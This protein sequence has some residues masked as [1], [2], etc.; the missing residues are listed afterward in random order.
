MINAIQPIH[1]GGHYDAVISR[2]RIEGAGSAFDCRLELPDSVRISRPRGFTDPEEFDITVEV[3]NMAD[4]AKR[5]WYIDL[6]LPPRLELSGAGQSLR[7]Q[8]TPDIFTPGMRRRHTWHVRVRSTGAFE[9][10]V[11]RVRT[12]FGGVALP[13]DCPPGYGDCEQI[14]PL[15]FYDDIVPEMQCTLTV[16]DSLALEND[17]LTPNPFPATYTLQNLGPDLARI[18]TLTLAGGGGMGVR[19]VGAATKQ[20]RDL[21][22]NEADAASWQ[23]EAERRPFAREVA[24]RVVAND[25]WGYPLS[26]CQRTLHIPAAEVYCRTR[27]DTVATYYVVSGML[28][29]DSVVARLEIENPSDTVRRIL[30]ARCD[31]SQAPLLRLRPGSSTDQ[32][33]MLLPARGRKSYAWSFELATTPERDTTQ[34]VVLRYQTAIDSSWHACEWTL[35]LRLV[36]A[37]VVCAITAEDSVRAQDLI[38]GPALPLVYTLTNIGTVAA[39]VDHYELTITAAAG[40]PS[41]GLVSLDPL[42]HPGGSIA[43]GNATQITWRLRAD[44]LRTARIAECTV[45]AYDRDDSVLSVCAHE[46]HIEGLDAGLTCQ[47]TGVD[48]V[49]FDRTDLRYIPDTLTLALTLENLLDS[50]ETRIEAELDLTGAPRLRLDPSE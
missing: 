1:R 22:V 16:P 48:T 46:M 4:E 2:F 28:R 34:T 38:G 11:V 13:K 27:G 29:P 35:R 9:D 6:E 32:G 49:R 14:L 44:I 7:V 15:R 26:V 5:L 40:A 24:V 8:M 3:E 41:A 23:V 45:T 50:E 31:L 43:A 10:A 17:R 12:Y 25:I 39:E 19:A 18:A 42:L 21:S 47:L 33:L 37:S 36:D 20:G 30:S